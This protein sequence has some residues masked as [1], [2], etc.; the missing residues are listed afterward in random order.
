MC[1]CRILQNKSILNKLM[2]VLDND[3]EAKMKYTILVSAGLTNEEIERLKEF[4]TEN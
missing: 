3:I 2:K 1:H 4:R